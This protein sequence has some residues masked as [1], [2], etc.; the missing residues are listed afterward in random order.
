MTDRRRFLINSGIGITGLMLGSNLLSSCASPKAN[1]DIL[2]QIPSDS[3]Y[4]MK[5]LRGNVGYFTEKGGTIGWYADKRNSVVVDT[6]FPE[7]I[8]NLMSQ[9]LKFTDKNIEAVFNTHHHQDHTSGNVSFANTTKKII[10]H[11]N[12]K[13]N[14]QRAAMLKGQEKDILLPTIVFDDTYSEKIGKETIA[15]QYFGAAHT[16]GDVVVHFQEANIA[17]LGDLVF[18]RRFPFIDMG[19]GANIGNWITVLEKSC[20]LMMTIQY[21]FAAIVEQIMM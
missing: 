1:F 19:A 16:D 4:H 6:Q 9:L 7:Q 12:S 21:S 2:N 10:A 5:H 13:T 18:N 20:L 3:R 15:C 11:T 17:H 8:E 14:Q